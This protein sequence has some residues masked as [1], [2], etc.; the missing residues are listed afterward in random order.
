M[1]E[2][3]VK[4]IIAFNI[5]FF[6]KEQ[7]WSQADL[8][9]KLNYTDKAISKWERSEALPDILTLK[10]L[11]AL[12]D[13]SL[14]DMVIDHGGFFSRKST[15]ILGIQKKV[16]IPILSSLIVWLVATV[17]FVFLQLFRVEGDTWLAFIVAIPV[18]FIVLVVFSTLWWKHGI[19]VAI[20]S[21][22]IWSLALMLFLSLWHYLN[23]LGLW[24]FVIGVPLQIMEIL[25][26]ILKR[27]KKEEKEKVKV[28]ESDDLSEKQENS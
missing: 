4:D 21:A 13:I 5:A 27:P 8:A 24:L 28:I 9:E 18:T 25:W 19:T 11:A 23:T 26:G 14:N 3:S 2:N 17:I 12:F 6:R 10:K 1:D 22:I 15:K 20:V 16:L 7:Q